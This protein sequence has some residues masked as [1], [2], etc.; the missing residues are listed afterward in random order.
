MHV[1][2]VSY[3][4]AIPELQE[5][6]IS[7]PEELII[8]CARVSNPKNQFNTL[9]SAKLLQS[10]IKWRHWSPFEQADVCFEIQTS[11]AISQQILRHRSLNFQEFSQ[12]YSEVQGTEPIELRLQGNKNRQVGEGLFEGEIEFDDTDWTLE[13]D[14][15]VQST[16]D[17]AMDT[18]NTLINNGIAREVARMVLPLAAQTTLYAKGTV[19]D[20]LAFLNV[21]LE[22]NA[23]KEVR[24][25]AT[26]IANHLQE[27]FPNVAIATNNFGKMKG[28]FM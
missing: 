23:Q 21:R 8:Y 24:E 28:N 4:Q 22:K 25:I 11:R 17:A 26:E 12:R 3:T 2:L 1:K 18:Y 7:N 16:I 6:G 5:K 9:T 20:W 27:L 13:G 15:Y 19:R 10:L 14:A